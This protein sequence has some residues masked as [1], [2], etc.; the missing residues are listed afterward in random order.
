MLTLTQTLVRMAVRMARGGVIRERAEGVLQ[1]VLESDLQGDEN[2]AERER[3]LA[4][5]MRRYDAALVPVTEENI[6]RTVDM[7]I[8][9]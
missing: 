5:G 4:F 8:S 2:R 6:Q 3:L 7:F 9:R 1:A